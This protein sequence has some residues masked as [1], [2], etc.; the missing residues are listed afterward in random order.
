MWLGVFIVGGLIVTFLVT[1]NSFQ[2]FKSNI[3][4]I[5]PDNSNLQKSNSITKDSLMLQC[6]NSFNECKDIAE[7]K[8]DLSI[9]LIE[10]EKFEDSEKAQEFYK[11]WEGF[12]QLDLLY[13]ITKSYREEELDNE[14]PIV[15][16]AIKINTK[17]IQRPLVIVCNK[18]G[19][20]TGS[21]KYELS[22]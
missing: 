11:T 10:K 15:I 7:R 18:N 19:S 4:S 2:S 20:L 13:S 5:I 16:F 21:S 6:E 22:C 12:N 1:P 3:K 9:S 14:M 17:E 8:Y